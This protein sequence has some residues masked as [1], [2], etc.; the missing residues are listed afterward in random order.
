MKSSRKNI[1]LAPRIIAVLFTCMTCTWP[2][3]IYALPQGGDVISHNAV[4]SAD[5]TGK[6]MEING[7]QAQ[8]VVAVCLHQLGEPFIL[9]CVRNCGVLHVVHLL[10]Y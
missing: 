2:Y 6:I 7:A 1:T 10:I 9:L 5:V 3:S 4:I 8:N